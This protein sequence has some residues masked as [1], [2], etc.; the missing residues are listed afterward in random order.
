MFLSLLVLIHRSMK[1]DTDVSKNKLFCF[2]NID[3]KL[4]LSSERKTNMCK[5][6]V[7]T[8]GVIVISR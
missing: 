3:Y 7:L 8:E 2:L 4:S 1:Y 5:F 6:L